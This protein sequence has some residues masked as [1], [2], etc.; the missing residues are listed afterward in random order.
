MSATWTGVDEP[1][2]AKDGQLI[3]KIRG[4]AVEST[5]IAGPITVPKR[6]RILRFDFAEASGD[7]ASYQPR[8]SRAATAPDDTVDLVAKPAGGPDTHFSVAQEIPYYAPDGVLYIHPVAGSGTNN[9]VDI[10]ITI[11]AG[12]E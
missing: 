7:A 11:S 3:Y 6:G 4:T 12:W 1:A 9:V 10:E 2:Y 5:S 8:I